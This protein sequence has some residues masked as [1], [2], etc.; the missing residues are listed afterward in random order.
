[1]SAWAGFTTPPIVRI[2]YCVVSTHGLKVVTFVRIKSSVSRV[3]IV[4]P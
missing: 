2:A 3:T 4:S 1:M